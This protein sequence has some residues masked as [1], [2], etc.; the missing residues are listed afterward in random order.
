[1]AAMNKPHEAVIVTQGMTKAFIDLLA[2]QKH[3][4]EYWNECRS[5]KS[6]ISSSAMEQLKEMCKEEE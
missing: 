1:M 6:N 5:S 2:T 4:E 3:S